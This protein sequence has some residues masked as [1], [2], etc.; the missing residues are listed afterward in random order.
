[1][2]KLLPKVIIFTLLAVFWIGFFMV[3]A[4]VRND[5]TPFIAIGVGL[6]SVTLIIAVLIRLSKRALLKNSEENYNERLELFK[7]KALK[8]RVDLLTVQFTTVQWQD[9]IVQNG[10]TYLCF[11]DGTRCLQMQFNA[12]DRML[13]TVKLTLFVQGKTIEYVINSLRE[14]TTLSMLFAMQKETFL[15]IDGEERYLDLEFMDA[16]EQ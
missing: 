5:N 13:N 9:E 4:G 10:S 8:V 16:I 12:I 2:S 6:M 15:Y 1:M 3:R 7:Q 14:Q 11:R